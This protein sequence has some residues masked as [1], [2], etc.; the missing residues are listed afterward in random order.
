MKLIDDLQSRARFGM[1]PGLE[2]MEA[3]IAALGHPER[4]LPAIHVAGTNGK[5]A[6]CAMLDA[7]LRARGARTGLYT[8][9]HLVNL[10]ERFLFN[11]EPVS[12]ETLEAAWKRVLASTPRELTDNLSYFEVLTA[13][14]FELYCALKPD[15]LILETG[16]GGR[17]DATTVCRPKLCI[18][19]RIGL[20]HCEWL[21]STCEEIAVEKAGIMHKGVPV[22][23]GMNSP[24]VKVVLEQSAR[25]I[26]APIYFAEDLIPETAVPAH[27]ALQ[28]TFNQENARTVQAALKVLGIEPESVQEG[29]ARVV[30][31]GRYQWIENRLIDGA[32]NP[33]AAT[34]LARA[35]AADGLNGKLTLIAGFC[36][37]KDVKAVLDLLKPFVRRALAVKTNNPRSLEA[38]ELA[39]LMRTVGLPEVGAASSL[40]AAL[41]AT[42]GEQTLICGSLFLAGEALVA[43]GHAPYHQTQ[44][45]ANEWLKRKETM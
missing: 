17:L 8:S 43:L 10:T 45:D 44:F 36:G 11:G 22:V 33:P 41:A 7:C 15:E 42:E 30:W 1:N 40:E 27:L 19:T 28:G 23:V 38:E 18:I 5:G 24:S 32:H 9:P 3:L 35:L 13:T 4:E 12:E 34:A 2:R 16:L 37:D 39:A 20:D 14:A 6:V 25:T 21:G 29:W 26:G 31:N